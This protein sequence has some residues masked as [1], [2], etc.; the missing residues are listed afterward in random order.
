[1]LEE[2][3]EFQYNSWRTLE[4]GTRVHKTAIVSSWVKFDSDCI[5]HPYA[6][7]GKLPDISV[8]L[9][10]KP[11]RIKALKIGVRTIIGC[12]S[13]IFSDVILGEDCLVGDFASVREGTR[14]GDRCVIGSH[15]FIS[16]NSKIGNDS[17]FQTGTIFHGECEEGCFFGVGVVTSNDKHIDLD[18]YHFSMANPCIFGKRVM[19][20]SGA[21]ILAGVRVGDGS[22]IGAGALVT[23]LVQPDSLVLGPR[24]SSRLKS[25]EEPLPSR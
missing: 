18:D 16:Y 13:V 24:A 12:H 17:R 7:V 20:G 21:N 10:R 19:V 4:N 3:G 1:M 15:V 11:E 2:F 6:I 14:I 23:R 8:A 5:V 9:A 25:K 22:V